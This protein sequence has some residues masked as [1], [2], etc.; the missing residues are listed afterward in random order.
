MQIFEMK[1][2]IPFENPLFAFVILDLQ[3]VR[4]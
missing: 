4:F 2:V 3:I 1:L